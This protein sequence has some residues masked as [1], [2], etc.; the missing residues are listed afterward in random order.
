[1]NM[2]DAEILKAAEEIKYKQDV[3]K[4]YVTARDTLQDFVGD[5]AQGDITVVRYVRFEFG[6]TTRETYQDCVCLDLPLEMMGDL[7]PKLERCLNRGTIKYRSG[8]KNQGEQS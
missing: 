6:V 1:M 7:L 8:G 5:V 2:T 3:Q 4:M